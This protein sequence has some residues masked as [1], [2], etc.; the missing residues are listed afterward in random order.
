MLDIRR[1]VVPTDF[2]AD[3]AHAAQ[4]AAQLARRFGAEVTLLHCY[5]INPG[6]ISPYGIT[7]PSGFDRELRDAAHAQLEA[8]AE[9]ISAEGVKVKTRLMSLPPSLGIGECVDEDDADLIVMGDAWLV[10]HSARHARKYRRAHGA[11]RH[12]PGAHDQGSGGRGL[13]TPARRAA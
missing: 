8:Q 9:K 13:T 4:T 1:I 3:A 7:L 10:G 12:L 11:D 6:A 2:S 5:Q